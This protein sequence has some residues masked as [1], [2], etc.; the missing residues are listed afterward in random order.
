[1]GLETKTIL[2]TVKAYP[3]PSNKY[4]ETVCCAGI[5]IETLKW[6]RL[7]PVDFRD[8][9]GSK[10]FKK[11]NILKIKCEKNKKDHRLESYRPDC[12]SIKVV[13]HYDTKDKWQKRKEVVLPLVK[14]SFCQILK[15][16]ENKESLGIFQPCGIDFHWEKAKLMDEDRRQTCYL[17]LSFVAKRKETLEQIPFNFYYTFKCKNEQ[18]CPSHKLMIID[19]ELGQSYRDWRYRYREGNLLLE[20]I[21]ERW[22]TRNC[23]MK[24]ND[25][26]FYVGNMMQFRDQFMVLGVFYPPK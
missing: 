19:W 9:D 22:L 18:S 5:D 20:K 10:K 8:L 14:S 1:M 25:V 15:D 13:D 2:I 26:Y 16:I 21:K 12:D 4:G 3:N 7:Y 6:I 11:Y 23:S 24:N 17:Q